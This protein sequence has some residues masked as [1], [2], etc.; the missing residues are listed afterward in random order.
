MHIAQVL[1]GSHD[2]GRSRKCQWSADRRCRWINPENGPPQTREWQLRNMLVKLP[3]K[4][5]TSEGRCQFVRTLDHPVYELGI[6]MIR[7]RNHRA[8]MRRTHLNAQ[9]RNAERV[10]FDRDAVD[11]DVL[12]VL[13]GTGNLF[14]VG[15]Q[16]LSVNACDK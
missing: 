14:Q 9:D 8:Q 5:G 10:A 1:H 13:D 11:I 4:C 16:F 7:S 12:E 6:R 3:Q 2:R 15:A